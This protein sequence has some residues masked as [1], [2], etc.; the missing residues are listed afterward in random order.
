M[1]MLNKNPDDFMFVCLVVF[2]FFLRH[3]LDPEITDML[4]S[5]EA[6]KADGVDED[7]SYTIFISYIEIYNNYIYDLLE[8]TQE[9]AIKPK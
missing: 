4:T 5:E 7:S 6:C 1:T 2:C 8:E 3:K 9:D